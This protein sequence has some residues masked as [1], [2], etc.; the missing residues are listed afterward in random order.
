M[1]GRGNLL[2]RSHTG[3]QPLDVRTLL[4]V[5]DRLTRQGAT[6]VVI[7]HDLD[8]MANADYLIDLGPGGE[9]GGGV[10]CTGPW[11]TS[12]PAKRA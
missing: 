7:E 5:F 1:T 10:L 9:A 12:V 11:R 3:L 6:V 2:F 8:V 4:A